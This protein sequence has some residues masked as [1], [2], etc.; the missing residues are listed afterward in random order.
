MITGS[1]ENSGLNGGIEEP[2]GEHCCVDT[3]LWPFTHACHLKPEDACQ[4]N[5]IFFNLNI[6]WC[7]SSVNT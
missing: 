6:D 1:R 3:K 2:L 4:S 7:C 5:T